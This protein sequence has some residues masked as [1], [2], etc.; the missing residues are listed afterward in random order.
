MHVHSELVVPTLRERSGTSRQGR[1]GK[2]TAN[3]APGA[4][5]TVVTG[6]LGHSTSILALAKHRGRVDDVVR[7]YVGADSKKSRP[8]LSF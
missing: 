7:D 5:R 1:D 4:A 6:Q 2:M 8:F 3:G